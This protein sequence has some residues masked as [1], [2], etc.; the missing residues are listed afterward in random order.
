[1][2][3][4]SSVDK[5]LDL[6]F[7]LHEAPAALGVSQ[8]ARELGVPKASAHRLLRTLTR[9]GLVEQN[10]FGHYA[11][12]AGLIALGLGVLER[13]PVVAVARPVLEAEAA[14]LGET[15]FLTGLRG[16]TMV[17]LDK[18]EGR[19]FLRAAPQVG[20]TVPLHATAVGKLALAFTPELM[21]DA[22]RTSFT[23][24]T[25]TDDASLFA[26]LQ[27]AREVGFASNRDEWIDG[28]SVVA[29]PVLAPRAGGMLAA[30]AVAAPTPRMD[31]LGFAEVAEAAIVAAARI[32]AR[33]TRP[34]PTAAHARRNA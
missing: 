1:L 12:G 2:E 32:E 3:A 15:V 8:L 21:A 4:A 23:T 30:L 34:E 17:V 11:P 25:R 16:A 20:S 26:E 5:A 22:A 33:L 28:L 29:A 31:A 7:H 6:L 14:R 18:A 27:T 10:A 19:G 24:Q 13:D 9:R